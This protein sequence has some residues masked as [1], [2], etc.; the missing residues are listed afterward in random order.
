MNEEGARGEYIVQ[1]LYIPFKAP[2][3]IENLTDYM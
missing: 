3:K 2:A 1:I